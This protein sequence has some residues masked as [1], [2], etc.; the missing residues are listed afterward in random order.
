MPLY[1]FI[2]NLLNVPAQTANKM[3]L[4]IKPTGHWKLTEN[5]A[6]ACEMAEVRT[7]HI[8]NM[9]IDPVSRLSC[10]S[11]ISGQVTRDLW[12][13]KWKLDTFSPCTYVSS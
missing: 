6:T 8:P 4:Q 13:I 1:T 10:L 11:S 12:R 9:S 7:E 3:G 2:H 5:H